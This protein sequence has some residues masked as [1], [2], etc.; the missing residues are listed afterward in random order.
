MWTT[1]KKKLGG[2]GREGGGGVYGVCQGSNG[3]NKTALHK[4]QHNF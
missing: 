4:I 2:E 3:P 1:L